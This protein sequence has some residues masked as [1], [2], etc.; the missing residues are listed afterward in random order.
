MIFSTRFLSHYRIHI[1]VIFL[2]LFSFNVSAADLQDANNFSAVIKGTVSILQ[3]DGDEIEDHS[4]VVVF[5][6]GL[7][8]DQINSVNTTK[9]IMSHKG[10]RFTPKVLPVVKGEN[11]NF[12]NDDRVFHNVFSLSKAKTFDLGI[13]PSGTE[14]FVQFD[15]LGLV[16]VYCNIHPNMI[17]NILVL[18]NSLFSISDIDGKYEIKNLPAGNYTLRVWY[19]FGDEILRE[20]NI[21]NGNQLVENFILM[22]SKKIK[23]HKNKFGL[24]Y[25]RQ[26]Y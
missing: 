4:N 14:K 11:V 17:S 19:E 6:D 10:L 20:V 16:K 8:Q 2:V 25:Y 9:P 18:N 15:R 26:K 5:V 21:S 22:K 23:K 3:K 1:V 24:P 13:Y 7:T 12:L